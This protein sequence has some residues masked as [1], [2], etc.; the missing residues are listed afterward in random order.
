MVDLLKSRGI[1]ALFTSLRSGS[2]SLY[3]GTDEGLSSLM[4]SW[5]KL[6]SVETNGERNRILYI[7][8]SR[9]S[10]HSNKVREYCMTDD[11]IE[12]INAYIGAD[13]LLTGTARIAQ[14]AYERAGLLRRQQEAA[15]RK[16]AVARR[17][18]DIE[19][20]IADLRAALESEEE[21]VQTLIARR[22]G[23]RRDHGNRSPTRHRPPGL[24]GMISNYHRTM[25][26]AADDDER[27][28]SFRL[29]VSGEGD[30]SAAARS[31]LRRLC[32]AHLFGR[33]S[34]EVIDLEENPHLAAEDKI[35]ATPT[36]VR[37]RPTPVKRIVGDLSN[38]EKLLAALGMRTTSESR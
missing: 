13:G 25:Y 15:R 22:Q 5:I 31:N 36:L 16:R 12:L 23:A 17:R 27:Y 33:Y 34:I 1:T 10:G 8:K 30:K 11:G 32:E 7:M 20:Q 28:F 21:E 9:G 35:L 18:E 26:T 37:R 3:D 38:K 4:D 14:M 29:Y 2:P 6:M 19:R 24:C